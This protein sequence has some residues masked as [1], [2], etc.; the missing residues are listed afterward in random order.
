MSEEGPVD[1]RCVRP[2]LAARRSSTTKVTLDPFRPYQAVP[3]RS[4]VTRLIVRPWPDQGAGYKQMIFT[5]SIGL[6]A[7][8]PSM[9]CLR[10][11]GRLAGGR[12]PAEAF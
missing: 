12:E 2:A 11:L 4:G 1:P 8:R 3:P 5:L 10:S 6:P 9:E 7:G